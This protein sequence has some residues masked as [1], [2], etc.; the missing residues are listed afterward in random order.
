[1]K[2]TSIHIKKRSVSL[3]HT[4]MLGSNL[5][6]SI[7]VTEFDSRHLEYR[8]CACCLEWDSSLG[9]TVVHVHYF[10]RYW[11]PM[12][13]YSACIMHGEHARNGTSWKG[14]TAR[15]PTTIAVVYWQSP[16]EWTRWPL[17]NFR[18]NRPHVRTDR[19]RISLS[20]ACGG[21][22]GLSIDSRIWI[23]MIRAGS[24]SSAAE[25]LLYCTCTVS[26]R[27]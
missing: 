20:P 15:Y 8:S 13:I 1:M 17:T 11:V 27:A 7:A 12:Q 9:W 21:P 3:S 2:N 18:D 16:P 4:R 24:K 6:R 22:P 19:W 25:I 5:F 10:N 26:S 23:R 14:P